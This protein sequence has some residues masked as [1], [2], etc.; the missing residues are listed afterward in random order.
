MRINYEGRVSVLAHAP[1]YGSGNNGNDHVT[2]T[3][4]DS[5]E[6]RGGWTTDEQTS[7][8]KEQSSSPD[9]GLLPKSSDGK[10]NKNFK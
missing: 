5:R 8:G 2:T 6:D 4:D 10:S 9:V 3:L 1:M 7:P